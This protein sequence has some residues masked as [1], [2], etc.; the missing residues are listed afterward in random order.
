MPLCRLSLCQ[1]SGQQA[2]DETPEHDFLREEA[3]SVS[4]AL[5]HCFFRARALAAGLLAEVS[6]GHLARAV[7]QPFK[8]VPRPGPF[9]H[10][11]G[12]R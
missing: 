7:W 8:P 2:A 4:K 12:R 9:C 3:L 1:G 5:R 11:L 6:N 10:S